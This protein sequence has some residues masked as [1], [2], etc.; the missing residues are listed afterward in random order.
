M[1]K[2]ED[3]TAENVEIL[4]NIPAG[5]S[6]EK[7]IDALYRFT[8]CEVSISPIGCIIENN[9]PKFIGVSEILQKST[10]NTL[11]LLDKE[12]NFNLNEL[13]AKWHNLTLERIFI[14]N[15]IYHK[16][17]EL[18]NWEDIIKTIHKSL[19]PFQMF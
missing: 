8:D 9:E 11:K 4:V 2:V 12:L 5:I 16:I 15:R 7:T 6:P 1:K 17:E 3:N 10:Q 14:E 19:L 18:D 13:E